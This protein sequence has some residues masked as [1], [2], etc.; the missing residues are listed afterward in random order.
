M[1]QDKKIYG[2]NIETQ[3]DKILEMHVLKLAKQYHPDWY[4]WRLY[5]NYGLTRL[6]SN[7]QNQ[8]GGFLLGYLA[9]Q[10]LSQPQKQSLWK[11]RR[12]L[13]QPTFLTSAKLSSNLLDT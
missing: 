3:W 1:E 7:K 6:L 2:F 12:Q 10:N 9:N 4:R 13:T 11:K 5:N 8:S